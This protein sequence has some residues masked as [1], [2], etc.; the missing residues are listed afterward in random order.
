VRWVRA[1]AVATGWAAL[2]LALPFPEVA[3][4]GLL[5][6]AGVIAAWGYEVISRPESTIAPSPPR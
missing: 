6:G 5:I 2:A 4:A 3:R 1:Q